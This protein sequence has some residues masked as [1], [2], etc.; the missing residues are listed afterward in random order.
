MEN[1]SKT[2]TPENIEKFV[3]DHIQSKIDKHELGMVGFDM[4]N[5]DNFKRNFEIYKN[6]FQENHA[7]FVTN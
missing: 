7:R 4:A 2:Y 5:P 6:T 3:K 1:Q